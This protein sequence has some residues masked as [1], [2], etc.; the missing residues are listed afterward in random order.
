[1]PIERQACAIGTTWHGQQL[2][3]DGKGLRGLRFAAGTKD[4]PRQRADFPTEEGL[5]EL[6]DSVLFLRGTCWR[7]CVGFP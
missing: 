2:N 6:R 1:M 7:R 5:D 4:A 3:G